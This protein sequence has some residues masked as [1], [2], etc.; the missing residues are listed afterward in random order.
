MAKMKAK[1]NL[2]HIIAPRSVAVVG[3]SQD[4]SK[5]GHIVVKRI[6]EGGYRGAIYPINPKAKEILGLQA[7]PNIQS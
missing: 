7:Y 3:A 1:N 6:I 5:L 4:S 2:K